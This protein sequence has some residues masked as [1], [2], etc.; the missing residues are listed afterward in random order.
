MVKLL[1][2]GARGP[3][4]D[5]RSQ[6]YNF[7]DWLSPASKSRCGWNIAKSPKQRTE[8]RFQTFPID[9]TVYLRIIGLV[10]G[11]S[12]ALYISFLKHCTLTNKAM[13]TIW[14]ELS[15]PPQRRQGCDHRPLWLLVGTPLV[16]WPVLASRRA[17]HN[18]FW[19]MSL[20]ILFIYCFNHITYLCKKFYGLS[21][22]IGCWF[23]AFIRRIIYNF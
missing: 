7:R 14:R 23:S 6:R 13:G 5:S 21:A 17:E 15:K 19:W 22:S 2:L 18:Q 16:L 4:F 20:Y 10:F 9:H 8:E 3:G 12:R 11:P 1:A